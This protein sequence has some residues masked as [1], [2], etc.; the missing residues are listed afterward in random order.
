V[1]I[2][3]DVTLDSAKASDYDAL[4]PPGGV[5]NPDNLR[6]EEKL[7][8]FIREIVDASKPVAAICHGPWT[9]AYGL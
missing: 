4:L 6:I 8:R 9:L 2:P 3:V 7:L 5:M 1:Q